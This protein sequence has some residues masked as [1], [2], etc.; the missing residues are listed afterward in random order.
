[1]PILKVVYYQQCDKFIDTLINKNVTF[2]I[3]KNIG[4]YFREKTK[5]T[6]GKRENP[7]ER[8]WQKTT[9]TPGS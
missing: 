5:R 4:L 1:M 9:P 2:V 3:T 7:F 6:I 8:G